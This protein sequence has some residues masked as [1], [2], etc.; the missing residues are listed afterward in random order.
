LKLTIDNYDGK[1]PVDYSSSI[2]AGKPFRILRRLNQPVTCGVTLFPGPGAATP[3]RSGRMMVTDDSGVL[4]F[5]GYLASEPALELT[6]QGTEGAVYQVAVSAISDEILLNRLSIPQIAPICGASSG[7]ALQTMLAV[8][9]FE[10]IASELSQAN[11]NVSEFQTSANRTWS[12]NAGELA[13]TVRSAYLLMNGTLTMTP[14]GSVTHSL[15]E[16][17]G[18][19]SLS[20]LN[21]S[22]VKALAND[23]TVCGEV[24][25]C[26]YVT[27]YFQGDGTTLLFDLSEEP[28]MPPASKSKPLTDNF[29]GPAIN[30][31]F[32]NVDDP[33]ASLTLT[34]AGLTCAGGGSNIGT[35][36]LSAISNLELGGGLV[37]EAGSVQFGQ[38]TSGIINGFFGAGQATVAACIAGFLISQANGA[39]AISPLVNGIVAGSSFTPVAGH[40]YTLRLRFYANDVQR[41]LQAYYAVGTDNGLERFG[42][43]LLPAVAGIVF[44]VQDTTNGIAGT[45]V[46]LYSGSFA[47]SPAPWCL[48]APLSAGYLQCSIGSVTVQQLGPIWVTSTPPSG[49]PLVHRLGTTAQGADCTIE[50][51]GK[52]QFYPASTPQAGELIAI[53]YRTRH[54]AVAR[55]A[56]TSSISTESNGGKLPGTACWMG[57]VTSPVPRSSADCENAASAIL[58]ISTSRAA[59]W[60]GRYTEWNADQQGDV[61]PGD[62]L[63]IESASAGL[64]ANLVIRE[65]QIDLATAAPSLA[66]YTLSFAND[67][68]DELAIRTSSAVPADTWLPPQ[69]ETATP[70]A[71]LNSLVVASITGS[72][73]QIAAGVAPPTGGGFE[74]RRRDWAFTPRPGPDLVLRSPVPNF[75]I[76]RH[77]A[78]ERY[79]IRMY[80]GSTPPNY[81]RFSSAV[82]VNLP[83]SNA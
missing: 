11:L 19:L 72:A 6:G 53:S 36:V 54:R 52:L 47:A 23:V 39:T 57:S 16:S 4:L 51:T 38:N 28:W 78:M 46:V 83:L 45:P 58:A 26:A 55:L 35:T 65:V 69:P 76:P 32:W 40:L 67:W 27:E 48:F 13:A 2:V 34:S 1:G 71:N 22:T 63:A 24:E 80:D 75:T 25:P 14:V 62:V 7:Q 37:I 10:D 20:G 43:H 33:G 49:T 8:L 18:T 12:E 50:R 21:L 82:F 3:A 5:T 42:A 41:L 74:V 30:T 70:L 44:E 9:D 77:A 61:W 56:N 68:A 64:N 73:I 79:Y 66:K 17:Q 59:A 15:G 29:Q 81:S 31:Q 60:Q